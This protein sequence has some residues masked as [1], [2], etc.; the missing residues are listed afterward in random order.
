MLPPLGPGH[1]HVDVAAAAGR[2]DEPLAPLRNRHVGAILLRHL[3]GVGLDL[4]AARL[5]PHDQP[6][7]GRSRVAERHRRPGS[8]F[9]QPSYRE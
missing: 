2:A 6:H 9:H 3:G 7:A 1:H 4:M 8:R 5:A